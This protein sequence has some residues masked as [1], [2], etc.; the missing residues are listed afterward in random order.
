[1]NLQFY[2]KL[3]NNQLQKKG[4]HFASIELLTLQRLGLKTNKT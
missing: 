4:E 1:M 2:H 3:K